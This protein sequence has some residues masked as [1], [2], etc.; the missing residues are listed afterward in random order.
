[1]T[2]I[3][4]PQVQQD[5]D[6]A[7]A[8]YEAAGGSHL[9]DRFEAGLHASLSAIKAAPTRFPF[10]NRSKVFRRMRLKDFPYIVIYREI[11]GGVRVIVL[12]HERRHPLHELNRW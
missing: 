1:M 3:F 6:D 5:F 11:V 12:R 4:H 10:Y 9:A 7:I 2:L 8:Y